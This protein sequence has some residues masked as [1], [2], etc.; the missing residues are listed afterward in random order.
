ML[1]I[2]KFPFTLPCYLISPCVFSRVYN[3]DCVMEVAKNA[4]PPYEDHTDLHRF[5]E[6]KNKKKTRWSPWEL[7]LDVLFTLRL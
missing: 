4:I 6:D 5:P 1:N 2:L 3:L 7:Q